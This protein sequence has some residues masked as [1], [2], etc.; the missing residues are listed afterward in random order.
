MP[1][2]RALKET[3]R[4]QKPASKGDITKSSAS[5]N[6]KKTKQYTWPKDTAAVGPHYDQDNYSPKG[7]AMGVKLGY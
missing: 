7:S 3:M 2:S 1:G 6:T 5:I 4:S